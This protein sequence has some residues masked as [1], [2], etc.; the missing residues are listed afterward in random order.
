VKAE[1]RVIRAGGAAGTISRAS[2]RFPAI[3]KKALVS[4]RN[5][6]CPVLP[7]GLQRKNTPQAAKG[8]QTSV[9]CSQPGILY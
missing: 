6:D 9:N 1:G 7:V 2:S 5:S 8:V 3:R 4:K